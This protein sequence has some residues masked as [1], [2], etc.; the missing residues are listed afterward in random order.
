MPQELK[1]ILRIVKEVK[2]CAIPRRSG[3][4]CSCSTWG[5]KNAVLVVRF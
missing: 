2:E 4:L 3:E 5:N 1:A